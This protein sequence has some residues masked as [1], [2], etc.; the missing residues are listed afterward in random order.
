MRRNKTTEKTE[1]NKVDCRGYRMEG[2]GEG[3]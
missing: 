3:H 2:E 1:E